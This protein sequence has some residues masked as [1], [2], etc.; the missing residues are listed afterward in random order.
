MHGA[1]SQ[2]FRVVS[3]VLHLGNIDF[4][5]GGNDTSTVKESTHEAL[6]SVAELMGLDPQLLTTRLTM[7]NITIRSQV[8]TKPLSKV[9]ADQ[10]RDAMVKHVY[11]ALFNYI[12]SRI[13]EELWAPGAR[14][15][16]L[17]VRVLVRLCYLGTCFRSLR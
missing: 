14:Q 2:I 8:I 15:E 9:E 6:E 13:N 7:R 16:G 5:P 11:T 3:G 4:E 1:S 10:N 17:K 12:V